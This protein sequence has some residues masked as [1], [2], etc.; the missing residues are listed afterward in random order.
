MATGSPAALEAWASS[1]LPG[2]ERLRQELLNERH[3]EV[4]DTHERDVLDNLAAAVVAIAARNPAEFLE[5]STD[6]A[7]DASTFVLDGLGTSLTTKPPVDLWRRPRRR[8]GRCACAPRS[9]SAADRRLMPG[10]PSPSC[11]VIPTPWFDI[12]PRRVL[13]TGHADGW[14]R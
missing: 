10:R 8:T 14:R 11:G 13:R 3:I 4:P 9:A 12:M 7:F 1:G 5:V 6:P 2:L